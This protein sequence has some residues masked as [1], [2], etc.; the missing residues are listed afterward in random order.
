ML[1]GVSAVVN[2]KDVCDL[3]SL[4]LHLTLRTF[5]GVQYPY[6][7]IILGG[8]N[9]EE[10]IEKR[11]PVYRIMFLNVYNLKLVLIICTKNFIQSPKCYPF[12]GLPLIGY[13]PVELTFDFC[14]SLI[15]S[16]KSF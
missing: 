5:R 13:C 10:G 9:V 3:D 11:H 8:T 7:K 4:H 15:T 6:S 14:K 1:S 12:S 2:S 16:D